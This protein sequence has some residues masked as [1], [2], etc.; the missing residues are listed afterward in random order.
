M[1]IRWILAPAAALLLA[2]APREGVAVHWAEGTVHGFLELRSQNNELLA[3]GD[4]LQVP[5]DS[6]IES[7]LVFHFN[8]SSVFRETVT[9][10]Q[11]GVFRLESYHLVQNGRAFAADLDVTLSGDGQ[12]AVTSTS[13]KDGKQDHYSG[14]LNLPADVYNGLIPVIGKNLDRQ[15][16]QTVHVVAFT[17]KPI[18]IPL[19]FV[20][21][22]QDPGVVR[23]TLKP[24]L[25]L[26]Q[27]VGA[28][29]KHQTPP[30]SYLWIVTKD[31][32]AFVRFEG[33]MYSGPIWRV[34]QR[35]PRW[36]GER[37]RT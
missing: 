27:R 7:R 20:P 2:P 8:D 11:H 21:R 34:D 13:H 31:V 9:F 1:D 25:N 18:V 36:S 5:R 17:P 16:A 33:P 12:Y 37:P 28:A 35:S 32:P 26:L 24:K 10:T 23:Y 14:K 4:Q 15:N 6:D 22:A 29:L 3:E 19:E 30:D